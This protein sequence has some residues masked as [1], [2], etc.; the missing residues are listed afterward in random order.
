MSL[1]KLKNKADAALDNN[2]KSLPFRLLFQDEA[3][4]GPIGQPRSC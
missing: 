1:K 4:F 3:G 2:G